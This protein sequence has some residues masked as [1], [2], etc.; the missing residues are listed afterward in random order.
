M[1][2]E[3]LELVGGVE[4]ADDVEKRVMTVGVRGLDA[5]KAKELGL[6][7][8]ISYLLCAAHSSIMAAYRI[9]GGVDYLM[10]ELGA[11]RNQIAKEMNTFEKS[12]DRFVSFWTGYYAKGDAAKEM[13]EEVESL[14][15]KIMDW[16]QLPEYWQLGDNQ[17]TDSKEF[18]LR[19]QRN[20]ERDL[21]FHKSVLESEIVEEPTESWCVT[22]YDDVTKQQTTVEV[23][24]DKASAMMVAKRL[25]SQDTESIYT[26]SMVTEFV[27]R[28][29][30]VTPYKCYKNNETIGKLKKLVK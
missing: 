9:Y 18:A 5:D 1:I 20:G 22:K 15:H 19:V 16:A 23:N 12:V 10:S 3:A 28:R 27:E 25:S 13:N 4:I 14:Y 30:E 29:T 11:K 2:K 17:H 21:F 7:N 8:R 24:M 26:A 6:W